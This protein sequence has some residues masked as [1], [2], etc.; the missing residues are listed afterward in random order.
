M[1]KMVGKRESKKSGKA[2]RAEK[3]AGGVAGKRE[4][5]KLTRPLRARR[6]AKIIVK[7]SYSSRE[8][9]EGAS[10]L[11]PFCRWRE[12]SPLGPH[13]S[14][15]YFVPPLVGDNKPLA[16]SR[17]ARSVEKVAAPSALRCWE[18]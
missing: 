18:L 8:V 4:I 7:P 2:R 14:R 17:Y 3:W 11:R 1:R 10:P 16:T 15:G 6:D 9:C 13:L 5:G 12:A